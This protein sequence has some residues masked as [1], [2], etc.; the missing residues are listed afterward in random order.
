MSDNI[1]QEL[2]KEVRDEQKDIREDIGA[3]KQ[4]LHINTLSLQEHIQG[5]NTLKELHKQNAVRI[6]NLE[7]DKEIKLA[8]RKKFWTIVSGLTALLSLIAAWL[9]LKGYL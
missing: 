9:K 4:T 8:I 5:V 2:L 1:I 3:I 6:E 7:K